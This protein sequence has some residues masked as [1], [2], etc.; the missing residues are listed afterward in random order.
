MDD[1]KEMSDKDL[2][3]LI[4]LA[5]LE[6]KDRLSVFRGILSELREIINREAD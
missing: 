5:L 1:I 2:L 3:K 6:L 4:Y